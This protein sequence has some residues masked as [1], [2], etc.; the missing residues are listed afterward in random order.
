[1]ETAIFIMQVYACVAVSLFTIF[2]VICLFG[3]YMHIKL[4]DV[5]WLTVICVC[6]PFYFMALASDYSHDESNWR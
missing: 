5:V 6:W 1:M 3:R 2:A 4:S